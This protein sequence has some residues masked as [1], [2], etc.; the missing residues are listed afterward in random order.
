MSKFRPLISIG[1]C[2]K[3]GDADYQISG[4]IEL[5]RPEMMKRIREIIPVAIWCAEEMWRKSPE[6]IALQKGCCQS[7]MEDGKK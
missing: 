2:E 7:T 6:N 3:Y 1:I 5:L 4:E